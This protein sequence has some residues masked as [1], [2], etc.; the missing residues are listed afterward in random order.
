VR[1]INVGPNN[2][3]GAQPA[4]ENRPP[5]MATNHFL[6]EGFRYS[7]KGLSID[8]WSRILFPLTFSL[9]N[10]YYWVYYLWYI[11]TPGTH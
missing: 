9:W 5:T 10:L 6:R 3:G 8:R 4:G 7:R 1:K 11:Q 2:A